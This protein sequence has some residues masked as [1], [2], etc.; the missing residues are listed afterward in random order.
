MIGYLKRSMSII[1]A[2]V[3]F[4]CTVAACN[5]PEVPA[6]A[7]YSQHDAI[8]SGRLISADFKTPHLVTVRFDVDHIYKGRTTK[9]EALTFRLTECFPKEWKVGERYLV[10]KNDV[11]IQQICNK[12]DILSRASEMTE[13]LKQISPDKPKFLIGITIAGING[14]APLGQVY[15][16]G[17]EQTLVTGKNRS[18]V[19][20]VAT[21]DRSY[22]VKLVFPGI[23]DIRFLSEPEDLTIKCANNNEVLEYKVNFVADGCDSRNIL[24]Q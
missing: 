22:F 11:P 4:V 15:I 6:C 1:S 17:E 21:E 12:T 3:F 19:N 10:L 13:L 18:V 20:F 2:G 8:F 9:T 5:C 7:A 16:N 23:L 24:L 14:I